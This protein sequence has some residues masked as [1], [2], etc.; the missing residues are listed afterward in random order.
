MYAIVDIETTGG[1]AGSSRITEVA[2]VFHDGNSI[3]GCY[4]TLINPE[5]SI[6]RYITG[7]TGID[8]KMVEAAP[9][10]HEVASHIHSLLHQKVF[11]AHNVN[12]DYSFLKK[13]MEEC[14]IPFNT[15]RLCTVR[16]SRKIIPGHKSY[17]LGNICKTAGITIKNQHRAAGDATAAAELFDLLLK[18]DNAQI[19]GSSLKRASGEAYLPPHLPKEQFL[20]LPSATG[21]YY[22]YNS[23]GQLL[24]VGKALDIKK[25][26]ISHFRPNSSTTQ[27]TNFIKEIVD[28]KFTLCGSELIALLLESQEIKS[29]WP[30][31]NSSQKRP[32]I[33]YG[34]YQYE[35]RNGYKRLGVNKT[36]KKNS[37]LSF[38]R[39]LS[40][41]REFISLKTKEFDL[42]PKLTG[43]QH[44]IAECYDHTKDLCKG[45]CIG[46]ESSTLYNI[47][48]DEA[49]NSFSSMDESFVIVT[50]GRSRGERSYVLIERGKYIGF[51]FCPSKSDFT[52]I[53][54]LKLNINLCHDNSDVQGIIK[55]WLHTKE[56]Y[57]AYTLNIEENTEAVSL[58]FS[59]PIGLFKDQVLL[60]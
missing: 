47:R 17:S 40:E 10:F 49:L 34:V 23:K 39:T 22:F 11:I 5:T 19:I 48:H 18:K 43:L 7:L 32:S 9:K 58:H 21:V 25:R 57:K 35:D 1:Y 29:K 46:A 60:N 4:E 6:P 52:D 33:H 44:T 27:R 12:F 41:A 42:C 24:Y 2:I 51:G 59:P 54:F 8:D 3:T 16:L 30:R 37:S 53:T 14:G 50:K 28:I 45:A 38:F 20:K 55:S 13:Q 31:Y 36:T 26:V 56:D 15:K